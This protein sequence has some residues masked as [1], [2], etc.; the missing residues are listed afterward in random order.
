MALPKPSQT[1]GP[2]ADTLSLSPSLRVTLALQPAGWRPQPA[3][4]PSAFHVTPAR[5]LMEALHT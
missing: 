2:S 3:L 5:L 4:P 1:A